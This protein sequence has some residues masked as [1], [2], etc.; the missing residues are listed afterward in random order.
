MKKTNARLIM[1]FIQTSLFNSFQLHL[2]TCKFPTLVEEQMFINYHKN[3]YKAVAGLVG[4]LGGSFLFFSLMLMFKANQF[5][6]LPIALMGFGALAMSLGMRLQ[7][8]KNKNMVNQFRN[9]KS[10]ASAGWK[11]FLSGGIATVLLT[12]FSFIT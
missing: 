10:Y 7:I 9:G 6:Y 2:T 1:Q 12:V 5:E 4:V 3:T 11:I 8:V